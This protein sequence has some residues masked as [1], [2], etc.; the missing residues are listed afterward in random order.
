MNFVS[1]VPASTPYPSLVFSALPYYIWIIIV[2][3][4]GILA[5]CVYRWNNQ[6]QW[7]N[8]TGFQMLTMGASF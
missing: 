6:E 7:G 2:I 5:N 4:L 3:K 1:F 8:R